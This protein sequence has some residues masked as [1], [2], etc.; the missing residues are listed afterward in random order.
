MWILDNFFHPIPYRLVYFFFTLCYLFNL[1]IKFLQFYIDF[2][3]CSL[4]QT[5]SVPFIVFQHNKLISVSA[6][7]KT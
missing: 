2:I 4:L 7:F 1:P 6:N 3:V 5:F